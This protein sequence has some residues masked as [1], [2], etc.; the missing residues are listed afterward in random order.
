MLKTFSRHVF[1][2]SSR[3]LE[4]QPMFAGNTFVLIKMS[5]IRLEDV[6]WRP[7][8][9]TSSRRLHLFHLFIK[10]NVWVV[11]DYLLVI[12]FMNRGYIWFYPYICEHAMVYGISKYITWK[13]ATSCWW[14]Q[15]NIIINTYKQNG[16]SKSYKFSWQQNNQSSK[17][18]KTGLKWIMKHMEH[19]TQI[20]K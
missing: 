8:R 18:K 1:K 3:R 7:R 19:A 13:T 12:F 20:V 9:K 2:T 14:A 17:L 4:D 15:I 11:I 16:V 5:W 10:T 6:F